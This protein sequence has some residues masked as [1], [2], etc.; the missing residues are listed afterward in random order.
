[1][2][3]LYL[4][5]IKRVQFVSPYRRTV[6]YRCFTGSRFFAGQ[7][8]AVSQQ[9]RLQTTVWVACLINSGSTDPVQYLVYLM[10]KLECSLRSQ[11]CGMLMPCSLADTD[12]VLDKF[13]TSSSPWKWW[14]HSTEN[15]MLAYR[16]WSYWTSRGSCSLLFI[17]C[18][19][20]ILSVM[21][22]L[23]ITQSL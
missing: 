1:M 9:W 10:P 8:W 22:L 20:R 19:K 16:E 15:V 21:K 13:V 5:F 12:Q 17:L 14:H 7:N 18:M 11:S 2:S 6:G 3:T 23:N 4:R